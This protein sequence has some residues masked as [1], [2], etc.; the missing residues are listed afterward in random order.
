[1]D[2]VS[3]RQRIV[4]GVVITSA[5]GRSWVGGLIQGEGCIE[6]HYV[7]SMDSTAIQLAFGMTDP[8]PIFK[9][10]ALVGMS[11]PS[12]P[13]D[14]H[15][16]QPVWVKRAVGLR[17]LRIV[18]EVHPFLMGEKLREAE[19]ALDFFSPRGYHRGCF[20]PPD[21]WPTEEFPLRRRSL[22]QSRQM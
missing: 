13:K 19:R 11:R 12:R 10:C 1:M 14:D 6:S 7:K 8:D 4:P 20:R 5:E 3:P 16:F 2:I 17:A 18:Q 15:V 21:I 9:F 22:P